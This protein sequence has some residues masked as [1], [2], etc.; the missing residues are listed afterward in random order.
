MN[1]AEYKHTI[2]KLEAEIGGLNLLIK[3]LRSLILEDAKEIEKLN[4]Q[5]EDYRRR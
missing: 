2:K 5:L 3:S 1:E 4:K